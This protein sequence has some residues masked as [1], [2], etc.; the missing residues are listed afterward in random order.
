MVFV[1]AIAIILLI[2]W[3]FGPY[4]AVFGGVVVVCVIA[5]LI[6]QAIVDSNQ[7]KD[8]EYTELLGR[9][10]VMDV[11]TRPSGFSVGSRGSF[12][13]YWRFREEVDHIDVDFRVHYQDGRVCKVT[14][15]EGSGKCDKLYSYMGKP[16]LKPVEPP[17]PVVIEPPKVI[18]Q[19]KIVEASRSE[20]KPQKQEKNKY[21]IEIPFE[22]APN[23]YSLAIAYP[24]CQ[25]ENTKDGERR[26]YVRFTATYDPTVKGLRNRV[27]ICSLVN[28][29]GKTMDV[30]RGMKVFDTSGSQM[31]DL[32][33]W[34]LIDEEPARVVVGVDRYN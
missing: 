25:V 7:L 29:D 30:R 32:S 17:K 12:R 8:I 24:S 27:I 20:A 11:K 14:A 6:A 28:K 2:V 9:T 1:I 15:R 10:K 33:F 16:K 4:I 3:E 23:E 31:I 22:I 18:E 19:P 5:A 26:A 21:Y 34:K 13:T